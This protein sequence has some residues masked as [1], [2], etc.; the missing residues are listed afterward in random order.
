MVTE[1]IIAE[2]VQVTN[3]FQKAFKL[4]NQQMLAILVEIVEMKKRA[5]LVE[6]RQ[7]GDYGTKADTT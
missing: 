2:F 3:S 4:D 5:I 7:K 1:P 6:T